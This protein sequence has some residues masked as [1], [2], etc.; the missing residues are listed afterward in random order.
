MQP[1]SMIAVYFLF[2]FLCLFVVLPFGIKTDRE[3]G[4]EPEPG[5]AES[6]PHQFRAIRIILRTT[7][8]ATFCFGLF[9]ANYVY[10]W[11]GID[12][13]DFLKPESIRNTG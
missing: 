2:W 4:V 3:M 11:V 8:L 5:H 1:V 13:L 7:I 12:F 9:Y 6:A 10:G